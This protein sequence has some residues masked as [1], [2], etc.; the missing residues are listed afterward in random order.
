MTQDA[1]ADLHLDSEAAESAYDIFDRDYIDDPF[2]VWDRL[3]AKCPVAHS[4]E[5]GG[6][7]MVTRYQ[8]VVDVAHNPL[9]FSSQSVTVLP[10]PAVA[11]S[12]LPEG[13]PPVTCDPP[14]HREARQPLN[15]WFSPRRAAQLEPFT[16]DLCRRLAED[17]AGQPRTD[18]ATA[19][20]QRI[21][22]AVLGAILGVAADDLGTFG[23][24]VHDVFE[25]TDD[26]RRTAAV[27]SIL[28]YFTELMATRRKVP[29]DDLISELLTG[30]S[31][32]RPMS[33]SQVLGTISLLLVAGTE[34]TTS[35]MGSALWHL[36]TNPDDRQRLVSHPELVP[37]AVEEFLRAFAPATMGRI[38]TT[39]MDFAGHALR[40]GDRMLLSFGA[41]NRD[42]EEFHD[43]DRVVIDREHN[44]HIAFG[45][46][47]HRCLGAHVARMEL[48]VGLR[49]WLRVIP[50]FCLDPS[51]EVVWSG[52]QSRGP[53]SLPL[54]LGGKR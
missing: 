1:R 12:M 37:T 4:D 23:Q 53:R 52:G 27:V 30:R 14:E 7:W 18:A 10:R 15:S 16:A 17:L 40:Q 8:D 21:P 51:T 39:D 29:G 2:P 6:S 38:V 44:R 34:T 11:S 25:S 28:G 41:A 13:S 48:R 33:D 19:Y 50:E 22:V 45:V 31:D 42:P 26:E 47:I 49:E 32:G 9:H 43:A 20:T 36:A 5:W 54:L 24:D 3:R 46:G 35:V